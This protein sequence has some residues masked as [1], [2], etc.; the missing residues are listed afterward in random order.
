MAA[1]EQRLT[2]EALREDACAADL[3]P[4]HRSEPEAFSRMRHESMSA[5]RSDV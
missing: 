2:W 5:E 3:P 4:R 1:E